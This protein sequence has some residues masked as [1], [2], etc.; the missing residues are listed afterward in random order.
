VH[1]DQPTT[2][3]NGAEAA[4]SRAAG[5]ARSPSLAFS[6]RTVGRFRAIASHYQLLL[7]LIHKDFDV[8][9]AGS[10][11]GV[12]WTQLYPLLL[13]GVYSFVFS[14]IFTNSIPNFPLFLFVGI[15]I[16]SFF[17]NAVL[18][19]TGSVLVNA[20]LITKIGFPRE[21][22]TIS[23]VLVAFID[24]AM[25]HV[26]LLL[27]ALFY[28]I[29]PAWSWLA[30]LPLLVIL[31]LFCVGIGLVLATAAVY[32][33]DVRFFTEVT[34]LLLMFMTPVFY[35]PESVPAQFGWLLSLNPLA[36]L[37]TAYRHAFL[38]GVSPAPST[39]F[40]L[41]AIAVL[42]TCLGIEVFDRGQRGFPDAL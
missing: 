13:L 14:V 6:L 9:Y 21:L 34:V 22:V 16:W 38:D 28:G 39:W 24:L 27:G 29:E 25:S 40:T 11:L 10:F 35:R 32:L 36:I 2:S 41:V 1:L 5:H 42:M 26:I 17:S 30:L 19:A 7:E 3:P 31:M 37:V 23:V 18:L 12:L 8:R 15:A 33:R 20:S 4:P